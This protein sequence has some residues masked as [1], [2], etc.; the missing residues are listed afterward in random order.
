MREKLRAPL[1]AEAI[2]QHP[3]KP[4]LNTI[5]NIYIVERLN[6]VFGVGSWTTEVEVVDSTKAPMI[7]VKLCFNIQEYDISFEQFGGNDNGGAENKNLDLGDAYKGAVTDALGKVA[8]Y[9]EIGIDV[10]K[11]KIRAEK[12]VPKSSYD[13]IMEKK[14]LPGDTLITGISKK[15]NKPWFAI[16]RGQEKIWLTEMEFE[17]LGDIQHTPSPSDEAPP[18]SELPY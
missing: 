14:L 13:K 2:Q 4:Y 15:T 1:P 7:I 9:L 3:T 5:K 6:D 8:S 18:L 16:Q 12:P 10:F 17:Y 11:G